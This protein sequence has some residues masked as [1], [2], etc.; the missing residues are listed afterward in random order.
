MLANRTAAIALASVPNMVMHAAFHT[1]VYLVHIMITH[2]STDAALAV[3]PRVLLLMAAECASMRVLTLA[4]ILCVLARQAAGDAFAFH[5]I[6]WV[7]AFLI[8]DGTLA[9]FA[10][11]VIL[12][13]PAVRALMR[14]LTEARPCAV[15][16]RQAADDA[17]ASHIA[18]VGADMT[19]DTALAVLAPR[20]I[21]NKAAG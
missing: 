4:L 19:A 14:V 2:F 11:S 17:F 9:V 12:R 13:L 21:V 20:V 10:P 7:Y 6:A 1:S 18:D 5:I 16:A 8:A 15:L 3:L